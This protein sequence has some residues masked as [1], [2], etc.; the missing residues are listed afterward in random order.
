[1]Y[2]K[3]VVFESDD[4]K[5]VICERNKYNIVKNVSWKDV[6]MKIYLDAKNSSLGRE[7][8]ADPLPEVM[9]DAF[10]N[11]E[12]RFLGFPNP[13]DD[14]VDA[15]GTK[16]GEATGSSL[17]GTIMGAY[18]EICEKTD[19]WRVIHIFYS[20]EDNAMCLSRHKDAMEV[21]IVQAVGKMSYKFDDGRVCTLNPGDSMLIP[22]GVYHTPITSK[23]R[24][25]LSCSRTIYN[26]VP[27]DAE[28]AAGAY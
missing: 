6:K 13:Y 26:E 18:H 4:K 1:M 28:T 27:I 21:F 9:P 23:P 7:V 20:F 2:Y 24:I 15:I 25:T 3:E 5:Q 10:P 22:I 19:P 16:G 12:C 8:S 11:D 14:Q 17:P